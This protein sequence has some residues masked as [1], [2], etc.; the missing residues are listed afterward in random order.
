MII[1][2]IGAFEFKLRINSLINLT[3]QTLI[4]VIASIDSL[5]K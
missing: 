2:N 1:I 5:V 4:L 3:S